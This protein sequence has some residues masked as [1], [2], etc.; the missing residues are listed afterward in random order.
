M[1]HKGGPMR[2]RQI[3]ISFVLCLLP[4]GSCSRAQHPAD[5]EKFS[6]AYKANSIAVLYVRQEGGQL[7]VRF[8][9]DRHEMALQPLSANSFTDNRS[10]AHFVF[11][12]EGPRMVL[13]ASKDCLVYHADRISADA[14]QSL[15]NTVAA[16]IKANVPSPGTEGSA[17]RY[18]LSL[19]K[20]TPNY[21][22]MIPRVAED[23]RCLL[24]N[25]LANIHKLGALKSLTFE[26]VSNGLD[27]YDAEFEH[28]RADL[29]LAPLDSD[30][31]VE[32]RDW[33]SIKQD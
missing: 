27:V 19:E 23:V 22:E 33:L 26:H 21:D 4:F 1:Y 13:T 5:L 15:E 6:G 7:Y 20:G 10:G 11:S 30:G 9:R 32:Y 16:R 12:G 2:R 17:R 25:T 24:P 14:A 31:K 29:G 28:G 8:S 3:L 18:I